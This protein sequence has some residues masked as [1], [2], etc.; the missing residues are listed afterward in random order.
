ML[1]YDQAAAI[2]IKARIPGGKVYCSGETETFFY[3]IIVPKD[4]PDEPGAM[5]GR[6]YTAVDKADGRVWDVDVADP[7]MKNFKIIVKPGAKGG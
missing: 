4:F 2:A 6:T 5:F 3:F 1:T 7:R